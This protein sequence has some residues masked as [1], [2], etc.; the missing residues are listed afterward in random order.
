MDRDVYKSFV[1][2][3]PTSAHIRL[4]RV[5]W[6]DPDGVYVNQSEATDRGWSDEVFLAVSQI[7]RIIPL[8]KGLPNMAE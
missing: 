3:K 2:G 5:G 1:E 6:F 4:Q 7:N 8:K